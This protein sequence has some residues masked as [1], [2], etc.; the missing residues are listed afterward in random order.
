MTPCEMH[1]LAD[2]RDKCAARAD[3]VAASGDQDAVN[4]NLSP[5]IQRQAA[6][7]AKHARRRASEYR[8]EA[9]L[10]R[11]GTNPYE[12]SEGHL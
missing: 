4:P 8:E 10:L 7:A 9:A 1:E 6:T 12:E 2:D 11:A 5:T 3:R